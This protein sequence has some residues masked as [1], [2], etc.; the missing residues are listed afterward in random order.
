ML[1]EELGRIEGRF[2]FELSLFMESA[3]RKQTES[4]RPSYWLQIVGK[5]LVTKTP[6]PEIESGYRLRTSHPRGDHGIV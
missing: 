2:D 3:E 5:P 6:E 1:T 4:V